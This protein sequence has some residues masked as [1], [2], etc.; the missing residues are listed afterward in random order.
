[1]NVATTCPYCGVGCGVRVTR[2]AD[3]AITVAGDPL[4]PANFGQLCSKGTALAET[5]GLEDR[6]LHPEIRGE[7]VAWNVA[8]DAV[9]DGLRSIR[10]AHGSD[11]IAFYVSGQLLTEDYYVA[12]KLM[13]GFL[14]SANIDTNSRL[15]MASAVA[16]QQRAFGEDVVPCSYED[17][18]QA[19][20][21]VLVG[22]NTAWCHPIVFNRMQRAK[23]A[24]P[25]LK[26]VTIDPR[27]TATNVLSDLHLALAPG[28]D[29]VLFNGLL[30]YLRLSDRLDL[31]YLES[32][33]EGFAASLAA[34]RATAPSV[35]AVAQACGLAE[36]DVARFY[37]L[38][39]RTERVVTLYS[40]GINQ[41]ASGTD[42]VNAIINCHLA[43]GRIG[44]VGMGPFSITGQPNAMGGREVGGLATQLAAHMGFDS[45]S[46]D[47]VARFWNA[48]DVARAPGRKAVDM[49]SAVESG[50]I[51]AIW[52][53][54]TNPVVSLPDADRFRAALKRCELVIVS[55][56]VRHTDTTECAHILLPAAAWGEKGGTVT[57]SERRISRQRAFLDAPGDARP[58]WWIVTQVAHRLGF[59]E[60]FPYR[61]A[62]DIFREHARLSAFE[63]DGAR[64]FDIGALADLSDAEYDALAPIQWPV[65]RNGFPARVP[66]PVVAGEGQGG[67]VPARAID[68]PQ[69]V[70]RLCESGRFYF[71]SGKARM[72]PITPRPPVNP[73]TAQY[74]LALNTGR[75]RDQWHTMTRTARA[76]RLLGHVGE[77]YVEIHPDDA[78]TYGVTGGAVARL[79][80]AHGEMIARVQLSDDQRIGSVFVPI[81]WNDTLARRARVGALVNPVVDPISGQPEFKHTPVC[82]EAYAA[83]WYGFLLSGEPLA[84]VDG[85]YQVRVKGQGYWRYEM[86]GDAAAES[87]PTRARDWLGAD[88]EW[89]EFND[90]K[91]GR[92]RA[93]RIE[94]GRL[95]GCIFIAP[96]HEL[97]ARGWLQ[98][99]F[100]K[101]SVSPEERLSLLSGR[102]PAGTVAEGSIVCACFGVGRDRITTAIQ[103]ER[104][105][106][107][108]SIGAKLRAGTNCGSCV[109]ELKALIAAVGL[110]A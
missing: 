81:H 74:P 39:A 19:D 9:A 43:T 84:H 57:N 22:S 18:D 46:I 102:T 25:T 105:S 90:A 53:M 94:A 16:G 88:G 48:A 40:Q 11:A 89:L 82:I 85:E 63:N 41:S 101:N 76:P 100:Q 103:R 35:P 27:R 107:V 72:I 52:I 60:Q 97:P 44:R 108:Q 68:K 86:A 58:D 7:R 28:T 37:D 34:A 21:L 2:A 5:L 104:L 106:T 70:A 49:F 65:T 45:Q 99:L 79:A 64:A 62:A 87:W 17:L 91:A 14:G 1:M 59:A 69:G 83:K 29:A 3:N 23:E 32:H 20:L 55:D 50:E 93:A 96:T 38:Y 92:Y 56:C 33:V 13:K 47:R 71:P 61:T 10:A 51:K 42:R 67:D 75:V 110:H 6:L 77:P 95:S 12:N 8:L 98:G 4:H 31:D 78:R 109:P 80:S 15:C 30:N 54:A 73:R 66:S 36:E 24:R 26:V